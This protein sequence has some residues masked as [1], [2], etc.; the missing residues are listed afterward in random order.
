MKGFS[1]I[2]GIWAEDQ[3][4]LIGK[5]GRLPWHLPAELQHFKSTTMAQVILMGRKTYDGMGKRVLPGRTS[6]VLTRNT[7]Y[8]SGNEQVLVFHDKNEV[9]SWYESQQKDLYITGGAEMFKL[10]AP[11]FECLYRTIV[12]GKFDGDAHFPKAFPFEKF[13]EISSDFYSKDDKNAYD[14]I[15]KKY[16]KI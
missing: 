3:Q 11:D 13:K 7:D 5:E 8:R 16:Q 9:L 14:F 2:Y 12:Q 10:F 6:I 1:M 4:G 15:I